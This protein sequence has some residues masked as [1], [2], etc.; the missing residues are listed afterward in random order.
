MQYKKSL[1]SDLS[2][3]YETCSL[4]HLRQFKLAQQSWWSESRRKVLTSCLQS[5][6]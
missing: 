3:L 1:I 5:M 4:I 6:D 2:Q